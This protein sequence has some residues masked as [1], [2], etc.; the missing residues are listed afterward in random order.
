MT[1]RT[2]PDW[3][4]CRFSGAPER[5]TCRIKARDGW[6][7]TK[8]NDTTCPVDGQREVVS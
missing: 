3:A 5:A 8:C 7:D 4:S 6:K 2:H 1:A